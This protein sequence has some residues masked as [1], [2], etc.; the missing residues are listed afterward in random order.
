MATVIPATS[1]L[2]YIPQYCLSVVGD[3]DKILLQGMVTD[4]TLPP[5]ELNFDTDARSGM[6]GAIPLP[7]YFNTMEMSFTLQSFSHKA[8]KELTGAL[9]GGAEIN[10]NGVGKK[11]DGSGTV[12]VAIICKGFVGKGLGMNLSAQQSA[13]SEYNIMLSYYKQFY[14]DGANNTIV[15]YDPHNFILSID[16]VNIFEEE[17]KALGVIA[18][19]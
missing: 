14:S 2:F 3:T 18:S 16:G 7:T 5:L 9:H 1:D 8:I 6:I 4:V 13:T 10:L 17:G 19:V 15:I 11:H 12:N